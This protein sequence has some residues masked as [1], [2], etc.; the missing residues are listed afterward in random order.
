MRPLVAA[1]LHLTGYPVALV[2][3]ARWRSVVRER[4][5]GWFAAHQLG[6]A[7]I[8]AGWVLRGRAPAAAVNGAWWAVAAAWFALGHRRT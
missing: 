5:W 1:F 4:R 2:V 7:A 8:T 3:I 6:T